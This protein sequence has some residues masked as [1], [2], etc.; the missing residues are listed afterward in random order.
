[1]DLLY[2]KF[3]ILQWLPS[4][5]WIF[6]TIIIYKLYS[7][8]GREIRNHIICFAVH[9]LKIKNAKKTICELHRY[10]AI[11]ILLFGG[12]YIVKSAPLSI[13]N[14]LTLTNVLKTLL[15]V[16]LSNHAVI[17]LRQ[18]LT[19]L[20]LNLEPDKELEKMSKDYAEIIKKTIFV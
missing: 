7:Y 3:S 10:T 8:Y 15:I 18:F 14:A 17:V 11:L 13:S 19:P 9:E 5:I 16:V 4:I 12:I 6:A 1:M 20:L 2:I